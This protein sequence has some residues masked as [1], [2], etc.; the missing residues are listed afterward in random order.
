MTVDKERLEGLAR[1]DLVVEARRWGARR[2]EVMTRVELVDEIVR[3]STPNPAQR[4]QA[5]GF[6]GVARDLVASLVEQGL[7]LPDA[8]ALIRGDVRYEPL[9]GPQ[10]PVATVTLAE[11]YGAQGHYQKALTILDEV[12]EKEPEH[13]IARRLREKIA[14]ERTER[15]GDAPKIPAEPVEEPAPPSEESDRPTIVQAPPLRTV[16]GE[17]APLSAAPHDTI[18]QA[19]PSSVDDDD[20]PTTFPEPRALSNARAAEE[21]A[22]ES[23]RATPPP[24]PPDEPDAPTIP[25][26]P[27]APT[28][29]P[30]PRGEEENEGFGGA[31]VLTRG[32]AD[33]VGVYFEFTGPGDD[34]LVRVVEL[35]PRPTGAERVQRDLPVAGPRGVLALSGVEPAS[36]VRAALGRRDG[37]RFRAIAVAAEVENSGG[38]LR[39]LWAPRKGYDY[40]ELAERAAV[41]LAAR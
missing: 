35:R 5:R 37:D 23:E 36:V 12:L 27:D 38:A 9:R 8:A 1:E 40:A 28:L 29:P 16:L 25:P 30:P 20:R 33:S 34:L 7:N 41:A 32:A 26:P 4:K 14:R 15:R 39:L 18:V 19:P 3:L 21:R 24:A 17:S 11:I 22:P 6:F 31:L 10:P 13:A 2:P